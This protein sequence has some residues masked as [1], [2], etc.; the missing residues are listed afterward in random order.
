MSISRLDITDSLIEELLSEVAPMVEEATGWKLDRPGLRSRVL[1]KDRGYEEI[2]L[3][4][5]RG[6]GVEVPEEGSWGLFERL[7]EYVVEGS[8]L[9]AYEWSTQEMLVV[10]ENV[11]DSNL[12]GLRVV[13]AHELVHRAQ[14][15]S[16]PE[17][18]ERVDKGVREVFDLATE[19]GGLA[20]ALDKIG[21]LQGVMTLL[22]SHAHY[23]QQTLHRT[24][25][26]NAV[27]ESHFSLPTLLLRLVGARKLSQYTDGI[28]TVQEAM[29]RDEVDELYERVR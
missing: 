15:I 5:I 9:A 26:P 1:P 23:I 17:L 28:P 20:Q 8:V 11:D 3:G 14:H 19:P 2:L 12:D 22:E 24:R 7:I 13:I 16:H 18:F 6:A 29:A 21:E 4:R 27:I 10:R 25:F